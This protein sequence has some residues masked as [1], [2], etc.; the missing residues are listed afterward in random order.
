MRLLGAMAGRTH[1]I[2]RHLQANGTPIVGDKFYGTKKMNKVCKRYGLP[3]IFL[4]AH[5]LRFPHPFPNTSPLGAGSMGS[6]CANQPNEIQLQVPLPE[7][8][9]GFVRNLLK[10]DAANCSHAVAAEFPH[11]YE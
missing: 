8:L 11:F 3:R 9:A 5:R 1:Q 2:R 10:D 4:H 6:S 7:D